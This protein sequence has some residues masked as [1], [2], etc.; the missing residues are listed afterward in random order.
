MTTHGHISPYKAV[1]GNDPMTEAFSELADKYNFYHDSLHPNFLST[2]MHNSEY[3]SC[4]CFIRRSVKLISMVFFGLIFRPLL[5]CFSFF[6]KEIEWGHINRERKSRMNMMIKNVA[7]TQ[8]ILLDD[9]EHP[10][11]KWFY[12]KCW[13]F[14]DKHK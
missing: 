1:I 10:H 11:S 4:L 5:V 9:L 3:A 12:L 13:Q 8:R 7:L 14:Y 6:Y 2:S